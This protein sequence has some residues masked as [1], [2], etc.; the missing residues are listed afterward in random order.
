MIKEIHCDNV[1]ES[2]EQTI[3]QAS[4]TRR[5]IFET[6]SYL[7]SRTKWSFQKIQLNNFGPSQILISEAKYVPGQNIY[8]LPLI[9]VTDY[10][11]YKFSNK[12]NLI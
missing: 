2:F 10:S 6:M 3:F 4:K 9:F 12:V 5:N 1:K 7:Y 8:M 11:T